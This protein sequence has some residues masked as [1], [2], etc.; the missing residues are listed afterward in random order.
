MSHS[1]AIQENVDSLKELSLASNPVVVV[2]SGP[3][4]VRTV[5][6][7]LKIN[8][9]QEIVLYGDEPWEP[10]NRVRLTQ[11]LAGHATWAEIFKSLNVPDVPNLIKRYNCPVVEIDT[12]NKI[13]YDAHS[14]SVHYSKLVLATGSRPFI[15]NIEGTTLEGV[16]TFRNMSDV[17]QLMARRVRSRRTLVIGGGLLGIEAAKA[18]QR[19]NTEVTIIQHGARLMGKQLDD[20]SAELMK[21]HIESLGIN[22]ILMDSVKRIIADDDRLSGVMLHSGKLKSFDTVVL[23]TGIIPNTSLAKRIGL[24]VG[25]GIHVNDQMQTSDPNIYAVGECVEHQG[26][27]YGLVAPGLEQASVAAFN[28]C[29]KKA[30]Y[31]GSIATARLKVVGVPVMSIGEVIDE[32][33]SPS[34]QKIIFEDEA[35]GIYR[36]LVMHRGRVLG[37][38]AI[39]EWQQFARLQEV[40]TYRKRVWPWQLFRFKKHGDVWGEEITEDVRLWPNSTT[41]CNCTGITK[42]RICDAIDSGCHSVEKVSEHTGAS[43]VCGTCKPKIIQLLSDVSEQT[44]AV[45]VPSQTSLITISAIALLCSL[46][47]LFF[48]P[49]AFPETVQVAWHISELWLDSFSK[50][51]TGFTLLGLSV[52]AL[53]VSLRKRIKKFSLGNYSYWRIFHTAL[54]LT[55]LFVLLLH[56]GFSFGEQLNFLLM[57]SFVGIAILGAALGLLTS[58]EA[59]KPSLM[60]SKWKSY[61]AWAHIICFWP[62]PALLGFH[63]V[64]S[65]YF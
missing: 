59:K 20:V 11:M 29:E 18:L 4:G 17:H 42:G 40:V 63:I 47:T 6:E 56:T 53:I 12:E 41:V 25:R 8:P 55:T 32:E 2:G 24:K 23:T 44:E 57:L 21:H 13:V 49:I 7:L 48:A 61:S 35:K 27:I 65:Y 39:G 3:V 54:G 5:Q 26:K 30:G 33:I 15:P 9:D 36:K 10:Y 58:Y 52:I 64:A 14:G 37:A 43:S 22:V 38:I 46:I 31:N 19:S 50:Q 16:Y 51:V 62:L 34:Y 28:I 60:I 1:I 45:E